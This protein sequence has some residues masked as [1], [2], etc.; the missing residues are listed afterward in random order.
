MITM[1]TVQN[2]TYF[3]APN[4]SFQP[5]GSI[6]IGSIVRNPMK[7]HLVLAKATELDSPAATAS[8]IDRNWR[9]SLERGTMQRSSI[10][11]VFLDQIH[12]STAA[13]RERVKNRTFTMDSL[14]TIYLSINPSPEQVKALCNDPA[15]REYMRPDSPLRS[16]VYMIS[17]I[18]VARGF[19]F[20]GEQS[21]STSLDADAGGEATPGVSV[22]VG[23]GL[24]QQ[25]RITDGFEA[26][27]DRV[28]AYQLLKI[29]PK[30][31]GKEKELKVS[32]YQ[33]KQALLVDE[34]KAE[35]EVDAEVSEVTWLD[36]DELDR[37]EVVDSGEARAAFPTVRRG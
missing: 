10:W 12:L 36:L 17:G 11:A 24:S 21:S 23:V 15:V 27:G 29:K 25:E 3:L 20:E 26:E 28:F 6:S 14:E 2:P 34:E 1:T 33:T 8:S 18:K 4:W 9:L 19:K 16:P 5:G 30:G 37:L 35:E 31:W 22:G 7:P 32:E 13:Q